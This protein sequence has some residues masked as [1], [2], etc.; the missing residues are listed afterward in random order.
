[1][2][3]IKCNQHPWMHAW[4]GVTSNPF[5][6]VSSSD[7]TFTLKGLPPGNYT[8]E[9]WTATFG[10]QDEKVALGAKETKTIDFKFKAL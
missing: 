2:I 4:I 5:Y 9:A 8:L 7:G 3:P 6:A 1:M 10:T